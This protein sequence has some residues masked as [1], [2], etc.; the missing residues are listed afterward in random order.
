MGFTRPADGARAEAES[1]RKA[2]LNDMRQFLAD[3][4]WKCRWQDEGDCKVFTH[5]YHAESK[6]E[7]I[8]LD[9]YDIDNYFVGFDFFT[10]VTESISID[11]EKK[12]IK[13][14]TD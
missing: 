4:G 13:A 5:Y 10:P 8:R 12:A 2:A 3:H 7:L 6:K 1:R 9:Y 14:L 11:E